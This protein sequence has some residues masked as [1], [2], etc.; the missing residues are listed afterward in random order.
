MAKIV[1][2]AVL[3]AFYPTFVALAILIL[4]RPKPVRLFAGFLVGGMTVS[5]AAGFVV[6]ALVD[7]AA[8]GSGSKGPARPGLTLFLGLVLIAV[9]VILLAGHDLPGAGRRALRKAKKQESAAGK[10]SGESRFARFVARDSFWL[11]VGIGAFL[12]LPGVGYLSALEQ[13][14][15]KGFSTPAA[16][17]AVLLFNLIAFGLIELLLAFCYFS[18]E[19]AAAAVARF[20]AWTHSHLREIGIAVALIGGIYLALTALITLL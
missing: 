13:I 1:F 14:H 10:G 17:I 9:A 16:I 19:R 12:S 6:L 11:A 4:A 3:S 8:V 20:D 18:P 5:I 15:L 2:L 7:T